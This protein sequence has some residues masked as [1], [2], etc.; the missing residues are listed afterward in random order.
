MS[1]ARAGP[2]LGTHTHLGS[3]ASSRRSCMRW[4]ISE[5]AATSRDSRARLSARFSG[6]I[7][8]TDDRRVCRGDGVGDVKPRSSVCSESASELR[9][10]IML[11]RSFVLGD[12][13]PLMVAAQPAQAAN[14][15]L[16]A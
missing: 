12:G 1:H 16:P 5:L 6:A 2:E 11:F 8:T 13:A 15:R 9:R 3:D 7:V 10:N 4:I 14:H